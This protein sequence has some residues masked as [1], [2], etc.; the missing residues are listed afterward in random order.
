MSASQAAPA[1]FLAVVVILAVC[2]LVSAVC[3]RLGQPPVVGEMIA[4]VL[5]GPSLFGLLAPHWQ[6]ELFPKGPSMAIIYAASQIGLVLYMFL[7]GLEFD[8]N[9]IRHRVPSAVSST[10]R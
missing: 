6:Q 5:L 10:T 1:F 2:K 4:G 8:T 7:I 9:L 3:V